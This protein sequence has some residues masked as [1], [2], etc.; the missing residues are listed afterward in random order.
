MDWHASC[1]RSCRK[2][3]GA[4]PLER[5]IAMSSYSVI[6]YPGVPATSDDGFLNGEAGSDQWYALA[7]KPRHD[8]AVSRTLENKGYQTLVPLYNQRRRYATR[9][10]DATLPLFPG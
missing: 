2:T 3:S 7:V 8:K 1:Y 5:A 9:C 10:K 4:L 6:P